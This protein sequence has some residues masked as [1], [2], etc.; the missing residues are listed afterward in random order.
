M[1]DLR[2]KSL[3]AAVERLAEALGATA[4]VAR[5]EL[6]EAIPEPLRLAASE[7]VPRLEVAQRLAA[8]AFVT[9]GAEAASAS[10][11]RVAAGRLA[12]AYGAYS[13][14]SAEEDRRNA[15]MILEDELN[16]VRSETGA[17]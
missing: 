1:K 7:L 3:R 12:D 13:A 17:W 14:Q 10:A 8:E 9:S 5:W 6:A 15:T 11:M 2:V 4:R 16:R